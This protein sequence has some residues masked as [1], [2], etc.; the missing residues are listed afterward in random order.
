MTLAIMQPYFMPYIGYVQ[1]MKTVDKFIVYDDVAFINRGWVNRNQILV[2]GKAHLF[3]IPLREASQN[4]MIR[5]IELDNS[6]AWRVK[7]LRTIQQSYKKA[8]HFEAVYTLL[9]RVLNSD[10]ASIGQLATQGLRTVNQYLSIETELIESSSIYQNQQLKGQE[11]ILDICQQTGASRYINPIG[12]V[13]LYDKP[14][15]AAAGIQLQFIEAQRADYPQ[16]G[17]EFVPWLSILDVLLFND[18]AQTHQLLERF[19]LR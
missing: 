9:E 16:F 3:T 1:L 18:P 17:A 4:R 19:T 15:F 12:G 13:E 2:S 6:T 7:L 14:T 5:D 10:A 11:R 8:P